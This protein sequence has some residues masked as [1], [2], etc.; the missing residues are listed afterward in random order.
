M[1]L[2]LLGCAAAA[3]MLA[4]STEGAA[5]YT[6]TDL[7]FGAG[8]YANRV[9][10]FGQVVGTCPAGTFVWTPSTPN[11]T[12]GSGTI[13][14][15]EASGGHPDINGFGQV[16]LN[17]SSGAML[18]TPNARNGTTGSPV[19]L[20]N[21]GWVSGI[22]NSGS[23]VGYGSGPN[24]CLWK[25]TTPNAAVGS[26]TLL[27]G[28]T[29]SAGDINDYG[30]VAGM[31]SSTTAVL[32]Q[33]DTPGGM[34]GTTYPI[35]D[36]PG[37]RSMSYPVGMNN[38]GQIVGTSSS[39]LSDESEA[40]V[41]IPGAP[42]GFSGGMI[43]LGIPS[44]CSASQ[45]QDVNNLGQVVGFGWYNEKAFLWTPQDGLID[46]NAYIQTT[47]PGRWHLV[48]AW[49]INDHGQIVGNGDFDPD[50]AGPLPPERHAFLLSP[51]PEPS[52]TI[53]LIACLSAMGGLASRR[54]R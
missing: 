15:P 53:A 30:Q 17:T 13:L 32:W 10:E 52:S 34:T 40:F 37:N 21:D 27:P 51:V 33:P 6:V 49:G 18:W 48:D 46:L 7:G 54:R 8:S 28:M 22:N 2:R 43:G 9:N 31:T 35:G 3:I 50:G 42:N 23:C 24:A 25:P 45:G 1:S 14:S 19:V 41:W 5:S 36:L 12:A 47:G 20:W 44:G 39:S 38:L 4:A 29:W 16:T 26:R 11:G